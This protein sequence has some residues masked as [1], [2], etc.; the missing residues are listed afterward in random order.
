VRWAKLDL[1]E[2]ERERERQEP[3]HVG[4]GNLLRYG[5]LGVMAG[6]ASAH[7]Q[8]GARSGEWAP[9]SSRLPPRPSSPAS[10]PPAS[11]SAPPQAAAPAPGPVPAQGHLAFPVFSER[12]CR[13]R[14]VLREFLRGFSGFP[15]AFGGYLGFLRF[16]AECRLS[17]SAP[18]GECIPQLPFA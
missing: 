7:H 16:C 4:S 15:G 10:C 9:T 5:S 12:F 14:G 3:G 17:L 13:S 1:R 18:R 6:A 8:H 11:C 2:R